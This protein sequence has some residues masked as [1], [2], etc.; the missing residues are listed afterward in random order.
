M[1]KSRFQIEWTI[2]RPLTCTCECGHGELLHF[3]CQPG[4]GTFNCFEKC[5]E[6]QKNHKADMSH[7]MWRQTNN[8]DPD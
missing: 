8:C 6:A 5:A 1:S 7:C 4:R 2:T 3:D